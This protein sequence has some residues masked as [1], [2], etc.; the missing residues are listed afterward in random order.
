[1]DK[2]VLERPTPAKASRPKWRNI[3][4]SPAGWE[5]D[6]VADAKG[7]VQLDKHLMM[8]PF[9]HVSLE[10]AEQRAIDRL[11]KHGGPGG[12]WE[13]VTYAGSVRVEAD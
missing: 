7:Y 2:Q 5:H 8:P 11:R 10:V 1:M 12:A 6:P 9:L 13:G 3:Y 4:H